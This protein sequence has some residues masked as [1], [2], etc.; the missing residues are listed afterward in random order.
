LKSDFNKRII[1]LIIFS[2]CLFLG[3]I[4]YLTYFQLFIGDKIVDNPYNKRQWAREDNTLRGFIY[5]RNGVELATTDVVEDTPVRIYP[6][7][8]MYSHVIGY[9]SKQ[10]GKYGIENYYNDTLMAMNDGTTVARIKEQIT[11][12]MIRGNHLVLT[13]DHEIQKNAERLLRGKRGSIVA[14]DPS[15]GEVLAMVSKPDFSPNNLTEQWDRLINDDKSPLLNRS[16]SGLYPPGSTYKVVVA[17]SVLENLNSVDT[18]HNCTGSIVVDGYEISDYGKIAHG[19]VDLKKSLT[20][21]CN[22]NFV[23]MGVELGVGKIVD[24]SNKFFIGKSI[25]SDMPLRQS[26]IP[27]ES[28]I[29]STE[30]GAM[31]IGQGKLLMTPMHMALVA[32][33]V[34]NNGVMLEPHIVREI[35]N[36]NGRILQR[37][38]GQSHRVISSNI[39]QELKDMMVAVVNEGTGKNARIQGVKVGGK[40]GTAQTDSGGDHS[41]FIGFAPAD[42]PRIAIAVVLENEG[43]SGGQAAAPIAREVMQV[44]LKRGGN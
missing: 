2:S 38:G 42:N 14:I 5:D 33:T 30:L 11:G 39:A 12:E 9:S 31:S 21:S 22:S 8:K 17:A 32:S 19:A 34:A 26:R 24:I 13:I 15:T 7:E 41:M 27:K 10:Y 37:G 18:Q 40:T 43:R 36:F 35:Q 3:M 23:R 25:E 1:H 16:L 4:V 28:E 20:E 29:E 44:V 6:F